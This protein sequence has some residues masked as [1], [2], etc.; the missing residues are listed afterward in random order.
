MLLMQQGNKHIILLINHFAT[1][2]QECK[3]QIANSGK[4]Y[5]LLFSIVGIAL[6]ETEASAASP[7]TS[8]VFNISCV[9]RLIRE[10]R[11]SLVTNFTNFK[12]MA[13]YSL[14]QFASVLILYSVKSNCS[15]YQF[16]YVDVAL[17]IPMVPVIVQ[18]HAYAQLSKRRPPGRL[19]HPIFICSIV[20]QMIITVAFMLAVFFYARTRPWYK[21]PSAFNNDPTNLDWIC[22]ENLAVFCMSAF[23]YIWLAAIC[24]TGP[25]YRESLY[26]N[27]NFVF[28]FLMTLGVT[29]FLTVHPVNSIA[30]TLSFAVSPNHE[31]TLLLLAMALCCGLTQYLCEKK[32]M[33][34]H[35]VKAFFNM[36][37]GKKEPKNKYKHVFASILHDESWPPCR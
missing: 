34:W 22:Y 29:V 13:L 28:V 35:C 7:F 30:Q 37:R 10:G 21:P 23:Q 8:K 2:M 14:V 27:V 11:C 19:V 16:I 24:S 9:P 5:L 32:V 20:L 33:E 25:P 4:I 36:L 15:N 12:Y 26:C 17:I 18:S 1:L 6:S 31:F 3:I